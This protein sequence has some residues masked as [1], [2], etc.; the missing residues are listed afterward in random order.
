MNTDKEF[1]SCLSQGLEWDSARVGAQGAADEA[2]RACGGTP[3]GSE[4]ASLSFTAGPVLPPPARF[5]EPLRVPGS[6][7]CILSV[8][9]L[10]LGLSVLRTVPHSR[11][12]RTLSPEVT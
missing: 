4:E 5:S 12:E 11:T 1:R 10:L 6:S 7:S 2:G 8:A 9:F 3:P